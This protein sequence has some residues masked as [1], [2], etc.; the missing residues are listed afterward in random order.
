MIS[1]LLYRVLSVTPGCSKLKKGVFEKN[2]LFYDNCL[3]F[4]SYVFRFLVS[5]V[6]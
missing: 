1:T 5:V 3:E 6:L 2:G 4:A